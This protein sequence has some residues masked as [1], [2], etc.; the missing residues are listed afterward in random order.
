MFMEKR[1]L[2]TYA[3]RYGSTAGIALIIAD[4]LAQADMHVDI[5]P[6]HGVENLGQHDAVVLGT[7]IRMEKPLKGAVDFAR[8]H[9]DTLAKMP[10]AVFS[11]G[12][13]MREDTP[14]NREKTRAFLAPLLE[15][16][17]NPVSVAFFGGKLDHG[18]LN[19]LL[20]FA[21]RHDKSGLMQE[22]DWRNEDA[23]RAWAGT[24]PALF[25]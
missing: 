13:V 11:I 5:A 7:S 14:E 16:V 20:R 3:S 18:K 2:V 21:A 12:L 9:Q 23:V 19:F 15:F 8:R 25:S 1:V 6:M 10:V 24:L 22:G 17:P 4:V